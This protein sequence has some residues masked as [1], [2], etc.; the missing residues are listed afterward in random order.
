MNKP[1]KINHGMDDSG[2]Q[3]FEK[4][5]A[6]A[7]CPDCGKDV[8]LVAETEGWT[9]SPFPE[10]LQGP[11]CWVHMDYGPAM[12]VCCHNLIVDS[13]DGCHVYNLPSPAPTG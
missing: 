9:E 5:F 3:R 12:G 1:R 2:H 7:K 4:L 8:E 11:R 6:I 13:W 10:E